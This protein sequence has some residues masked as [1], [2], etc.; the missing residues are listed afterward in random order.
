MFKFRLT[1]TGNDLFRLF[2]FKIKVGQPDLF[3]FFMFLS[4][5]F[6]EL[7]EPEPQSGFVGPFSH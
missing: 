5:V 6:I 3:I 2:N 1:T 7:S 4:D